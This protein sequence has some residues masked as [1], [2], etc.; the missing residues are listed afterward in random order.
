VGHPFLWKKELPVLLLV[1]ATEEDG[2]KSCPSSKKG[3]GVFTRK[4]N[5][6]IFQQG[7]ALYDVPFSLYNPTILPLGLVCPLRDHEGVI[8]TSR[9]VICVHNR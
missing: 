8:F 5:N 1:C 7:A 2:V 9:S 3:D 4:S 6:G